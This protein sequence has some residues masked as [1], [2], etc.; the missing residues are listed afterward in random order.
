VARAFK[1]SLYQ[2]SQHYLYLGVGRIVVA[3]SVSVA[4]IIN[5]VSLIYSGAVRSKFRLCTVHSASINGEGIALAS[6]AWIQCEVPPLKK[7]LGL[8]SFRPANSALNFFHSK[9]ESGKKADG[10]GTQSTFEV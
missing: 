3:S 6:C 1:C 10:S 5:R 7:S 9:G 8:K 4:S 2:S